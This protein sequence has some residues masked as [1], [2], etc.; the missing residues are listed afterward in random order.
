MRA[1]RSGIGQSGL[2]DG[3]R[4]QTTKGG[5]N[6]GSRVERERIAKHNE[7]LERL[8]KEAIAAAQKSIAA[9]RSL[10]PPIIPLTSG[11][12]LNPSV[13]GSLS[14]AASEAASLKT[15]ISETRSNEAK[16]F[17]ERAELLPADGEQDGA[18]FKYLVRAKSDRGAAGMKQLAEKVGQILDDPRSK[19]FMVGIGEFDFYGG[20]GKYDVEMTFYSEEGVEMVKYRYLDP[21]SGKPTRFGEGALDNVNQSSWKALNLPKH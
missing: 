13:I 2:E 10:P 21:S 19:Q 6:S 18:S 12:D 8:D 15:V 16:M 3:I 7:M 11:G 20:F 9:S 14:L 17:V 5:R 4:H 1:G